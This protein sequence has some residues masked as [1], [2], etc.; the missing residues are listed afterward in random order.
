MIQHVNG[1]FSL[2]EGALASFHTAVQ[3]LTKLFPNIR[4]EH[5][6]QLHNKHADALATLASKAKIKD[7]VV[8]IH[9]IRNTLRAMATDLI[10]DQSTDEK[11]LQTSVIVKSHSTFFFDECKG[12]KRLHN[13]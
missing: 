4:F 12:A 3:K 10:P 9:I 5:V 8:E 1:E 6:P 2:K 7:D 11:D 13:H